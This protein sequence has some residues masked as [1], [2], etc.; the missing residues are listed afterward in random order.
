MAPVAVEANVEFEGHAEH[1]GTVASPPTGTKLLLQ[2][3]TLLPVT[4]VELVLHATHLGFVLVPPAVKLFSK[5]VLQVQVLVEPKPAPTE[6]AGQATQTGTA[7]VPVF[8]NPE[9]HTHLLFKI[10]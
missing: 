3:Q 4:W 1:T 5:P 8:L 7:S 6:F 9:A 2:V 10:T